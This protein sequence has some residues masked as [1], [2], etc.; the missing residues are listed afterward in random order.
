MLDRF[1]WPDFDA[2]EY[3]VAVN[4][5]FMQLLYWFDD[6]YGSSMVASNPITSRRRHLRHRIRN[7]TMKASRIM[8]A[9][10]LPGTLLMWFSCFDNRCSVNCAC[11]YKL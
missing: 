11:F 10:T 2:G 5:L 1:F 7:T 9:L 3:D 6:Y 8:M 4:T